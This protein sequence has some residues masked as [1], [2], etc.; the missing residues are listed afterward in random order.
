[1]SGWH[2]IHEWSDWHL[3][4]KH[5]I[6]RDGKTVAWEAVYKRWCTFEGCSQ[7]RVK[8]RMYTTEP[9]TDDILYNF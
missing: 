4:G 1:M 3:Q 6:V 7:A 5:A 9:K 8:R 2:M